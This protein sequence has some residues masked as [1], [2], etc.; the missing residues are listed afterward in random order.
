LPYLAIMPLL[1]DDE[2][3]LRICY[4]DILPAGVDLKD[5]P[6]GWATCLEKFFL[7]LRDYNTRHIAQAPVSIFKLII[8]GLVVRVTFKN[9]S[10]NNKEVNFLRQCFKDH[11]RKTCKICSFHADVVNPVA[12]VALCD[13]CFEL[14]KIVD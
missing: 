13:N 9:V 10:T 3:K 6:P 7:H 1:H 12:G 11:A 2:I 8:C 14:F 4:P 5:F